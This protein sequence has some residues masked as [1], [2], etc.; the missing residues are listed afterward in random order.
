MPAI[1]YQLAL[2]FTFV[3]FFRSSVDALRSIIISQRV[4]GTRE[5]A[6]LR[7]TECG[8][9]TFES[10]HLRKIIRDAA[11]GNTTVAEKVDKIDFLTFKNLEDSVKQEVKYLQENPLVLK[12]T[13]V[14]GW[15][16]N[17][18]TGGVS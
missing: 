12:E 16:Y 6:I 17:V 8:M 10:E 3:L 4:L 2:I 5:I 15:I 1:L 9:L 14:T 11:P 13:Q 7:H 18:R